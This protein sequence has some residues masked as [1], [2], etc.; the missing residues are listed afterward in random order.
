MNELSLN[1]EYF[2]DFPDEEKLTV[3]SCLCDACFRHVDR[4]ANCPSYKKRLSE[5]AK[6]NESNAADESEDKEAEAALFHTNREITFC[7]V[8]ECREQASYS[9]CRKWALKVRRT[10]SKHIQFNYDNTTSMAFLPIC[11]RHYDDINHLL[12]CVL[13]NR[14]LKRNHSYYLSQVNYPHLFTVDLL[15]F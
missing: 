2:Y 12:V 7:Q 10:L 6:T 3:D 5:P 4:R 15:K 14:R 1:F 11:D 8:H 13:C 9:V